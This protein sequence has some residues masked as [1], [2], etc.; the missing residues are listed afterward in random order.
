MRAAWILYDGIESDYRMGDS[1]PN[2]AAAAVQEANGHVAKGRYQLLETLGRGGA[3]VVYKARDLARDRLIA[4]KQLTTQ[5]HQAQHALLLG[6]FEREYRTLA[7][8]A[9]PSIIAVHDYVVDGDTAFYTMELVEGFDLNARTRWPWREVCELTAQVCSA[10]SLVHSR[11]MIHRDITPR[12]VRCNASGRAKLI[13]FGAMAPI[14]RTHEIV[15]TPAFMAPEVLDQ[16]PL[17]ARTDL[18]ALGVTLYFALT[19]RLPYPARDVRQLRAAWRAAVEPPSQ[20]VPDVPAE[21]DRLVMAMLSLAP[22]SRPRTAA[23]VMQRLLSV[24]GVAS[25]ESPEVSKSYLK[26][27]LLVG[28]AKELAAVREQLHE[29]LAGRRQSLLFSAAS[30]LGRSRLLD[31]CVIELKVEGAT[32]LR[33]SAAALSDDAFGAAQGLAEQ[34]VEQIGQA[35]VSELTT[36]ELRATLFDPASST[37]Q[38]QPLKRAV[39]A[40]AAV[41]A[42]AAWFEQVASR[43]PLAIVVDDVDHID[44]QSRQWLAMLARSHRFARLVLLSSAETSSPAIVSNLAVRALAAVS[45]SY[46]LGPLGRS[47]TFELFRSV[48]GD[49]PNLVL[50]SD[51]IYEISGGN[52]RVALATAQCLVDNGSVVYAE[53]VWRLPAIL[54]SL[55]LPASAE[56]AMGQ[57]LAVLS[58]LALQLVEAQALASHHAFTRDDY[59]T[60]AGD[61]PAAETDH[62]VSELVSRQIL[63]R[64]QEHFVFA[65]RGWA[66]TAIRRCD[67]ATQRERH[68]AIA[69]LYEHHLGVEPVHH[70]LEAGLEEAAIAWLVMRVRAV[71]GQE[72]HHQSR[73]TGAHLVAIME[74]TLDVAVARGRPAREIHDLRRGICA[75]TAVIT[76]EEVFYRVAPLWLAQLQHDSGQLAWQQDTTTDPAARLTHAFQHAV[77]QYERTPVQ[78]RV[79]KVDEAVRGLVAYVVFAI[80]IGARTQ[81]LALLE[82]LPGLLA[83]YV[84]MSRV[85]AVIQENA[86]AG[87]EARHRC[88]PERARS[89]WTH[90]YEVLGTISTNELSNAPVIRNAVATG[91][92]SVEAMMGLTSAASW[93]EQL[94]KD[95]FQRVHAFH[96]RRAIR[97][98]Q[99]DWEGAET[100]RKQAEEF[101]AVSLGRQMFFNSTFVELDVYNLTDDLIGV[102]Q[103]IDRCEPLA[104]RFAGWVPWLHLAHATHHRIRGEYD[105]ARERYE[106]SL[107]ATQVDAHHWATRLPRG[108]SWPMAAA[109]YIG[110]L[111]ELGDSQR[112]VALG[113]DALAQCERGEVRM[114]AHGI[115]RAL[116]LAEGKQGHYTSAAARLDAVI[117]EQTQYGVSG[118]HLGATY[119]TRTR[120]AL[121]AA[122][123]TAIEKF[124][125]LTAREYR[126]GLDSPLGARYERLLNEARR[127][128]PT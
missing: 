65:H 43:M 39:D 107:V 119:E 49:V 62:A 78:D 27:P 88:R 73:M 113:R 21:L 26:A 37:L 16:A 86:L 63:A 23:E 87:Y 53:G 46:E 95:P 61:T 92:G 103:I 71:T 7:E 20:I 125:R 64:S 45:K 19:G 117:T 10:L 121:W 9:H 40:Y 48:F 116:A 80:A 22:A 68:R 122:D 28:R 85:A 83:P 99:G 12:N 34:L 24:A 69:R 17:D 98:Q 25:V 127:V 76:S 93:A 82:T 91:I 57:Q 54:G 14:G 105:A 44:P 70:L 108:G 111:V 72:L 114:L 52:P 51:G 55:E 11:G 75:F 59:V 36:P 38:L 106:R 56:D 2:P 5:T 123:Y 42:L 101:A 29:A 118:V 84:G 8:L 120:L 102:R 79:Y 67:A 126:H 109:G 60:L 41:N 97:L 100:L 66:A 58:P 115:V 33:A 18:F 6:L 110:V 50:V 13:D 112:A 77:A 32:V 1:K 94:E 128:A 124:G 96:L 47:E 4:L 104:V 74:R 15:G 90:V 30:G 3:A 81:D 31:A 89:M 35:A